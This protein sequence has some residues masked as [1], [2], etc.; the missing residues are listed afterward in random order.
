MTPSKNVGIR[1]P[2]RT[3]PAWR[4]PP[5][6]WQPPPNAQEP[7]RWRSG[8][9]LTAHV[10]SPERFA[11][12]SKGAASTTSG[13]EEESAGAARYR[14]ICKRL[15]TLPDET[16]VATLNG[17][18]EGV[19]A[20]TSASVPLDPDG[21]FAIVSTLELCNKLHTLR[22]SGPFVSEPSHL[23][24]DAVV[25]MEGTFLHLGAGQPTPRCR[26][27]QEGRSQPHTIQLSM[28]CR[29]IASPALS[30]SSSAFGRPDPWWT[31]IVEKG[32][33]P[34]RGHSTA[35]DGLS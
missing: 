32:N 18:T 15:Y 27:R 16:Y 3:R 14:V 2:M 17:D 5:D 12:P 13:V 34:C 8:D 11:S 25:V 24:P 35:A 7:S 28:Y 4:N 33:P 20:T 21:L 22:L 30:A 31:T 10:P 26:P 1:S 29:H 19:Y 23:S 9:A 6:P